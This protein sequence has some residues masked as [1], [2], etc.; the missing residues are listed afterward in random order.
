MQTAKVSDELDLTTSLD[1]RGVDALETDAGTVDF[2][3]VAVDY[4]G[5]T[6]ESFSAYGSWDQSEEG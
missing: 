2:E 1:L 5:A 4:R 6:D 3:G